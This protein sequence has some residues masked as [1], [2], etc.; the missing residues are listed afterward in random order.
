[1]RGDLEHTFRDVRILHRVQRELVD[2]T[3]E[4]VEAAGVLGDGVVA[5]PDGDHADLGV[6]GHPLQKFEDRLADRRIGDQTLLD[7]ERQADLLGCG[8]GLRDL[9]LLAAFLHHQVRRGQ[10]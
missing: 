2:G 5:Q 1:V 8:C 3:D 4:H 10:V 6:I 7:G 9:A